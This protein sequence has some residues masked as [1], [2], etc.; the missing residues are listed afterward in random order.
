[1]PFTTVSFQVPTETNLQSAPFVAPGTHPVADRL[2][3]LSSRISRITID[4]QGEGQ[5]SWTR[6]DRSF[7]RPTGDTISPD[8]SPARLQPFTA[9]RP[10]IAGF[11]PQQQPR[12]AL[13]DAWLHRSQ[14]LTDDGC[15]WPHGALQHADPCCYGRVQC[16]H[17]RQFRE[18]PTSAATMPCKESERA[19]IRN[20]QSSVPCLA[21]GA[22]TGHVVSMLAALNEPANS[23]PCL[24]SLQRAAL[25]DLH[26]HAACSAINRKLESVRALLGERSCILNRR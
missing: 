19:L 14:R 6:G 21:A 7:K 22:H 20:R 3:D 16:M 8:S 2:H 17:T 24:V 18:R 12:E 23:A 9:Y 10:R 26:A 11:N 13:S 4:V 15:R 5:S 25:V 1:M